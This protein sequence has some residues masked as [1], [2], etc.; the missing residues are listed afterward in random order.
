MSNRLRS[1]S[2]LNVIV[3]QGAMY[4]MVSMRGLLHRKNG[5]ILSMFSIIMSLSQVGID[6][7]KFDFDN[8]VEFT[9]KLLDE[10]S[11][12]VLPGKVSQK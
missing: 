8:D 5:Y 11:V 2:G 12:F 4:V 9:Q 10:E 6:T 7:C 3:P 1:L